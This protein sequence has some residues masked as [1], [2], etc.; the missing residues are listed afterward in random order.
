ML[1]KLINPNTTLSMTKKI[2]VA[3][4][5]AASA[6]VEV[7]AVSPEDG[8]ASIEGHHDEAIAAMGVLDVIRKDAGKSDAYV[9]ACFGD[10]GLM[11]ARELTDR[12]VLGVAEA[13]MHAATFVG[14]GFSVVTTLARTIN[15][16]RHLLLLYGMGEHCR[17]LR[18]CELEVLE[19]EDPQSDAYKVILQECRVAVK[20]DECNAIVL[21]CAGMADLAANLSKELKLPVI[22]GVGAAVGFAEVLVRLGLKT[23][24]LHD[25][26]FPLAKSYSGIFKDFS[27]ASP[28]KHPSK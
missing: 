20:E 7:Q 26:A 4:Q 8:V 2:G 18:A 16:A 1:I 28:P 5:A 6:G 22:D 23:G 11:A 14:S 9:I 15:I 25:L 3:G 19:L 17:K 13:A 24:K 21:G 12:P 27:P 10:P